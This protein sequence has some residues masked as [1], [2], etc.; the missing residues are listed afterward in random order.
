MDE[1]CDDG[2]WKDKDGCSKYCK[3]EPGYKCPGGVCVCKT[4]YAKL[5]DG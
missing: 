1:E 3:L 4:G 5:Y 2:N